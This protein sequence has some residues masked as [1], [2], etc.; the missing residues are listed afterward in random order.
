MASDNDPR[1]YIVIEQYADDAAFEY[2]K[3]T[4]YLQAFIP[5]LLDLLEEPPTV[6]FFREESVAQSA[7]H[8]DIL[9]RRCRGRDL[10]EATKRYSRI[11]GVTFTEPA[12]FHEAM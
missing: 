5:K 12:T 8:R 3:G 10:E 6:T 1:N 9:P 11:L 7:G 2:H 4:D